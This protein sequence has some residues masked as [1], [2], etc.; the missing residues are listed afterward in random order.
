[1][2]IRIHIHTCPLLVVPSPVAAARTA[3]ISQTENFIARSRHTY[4]RTQT[5][6]TYGLATATATANTEQE[7][8]REGRWFCGLSVWPVGR[9]RDGGGCVCV[10]YVGEKWAALADGGI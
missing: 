3:K 10:V 9:F 4:V 2:D 1:M 6:E 7:A 5:L 8:E